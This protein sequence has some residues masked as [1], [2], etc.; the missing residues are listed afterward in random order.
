MPAKFEISRSGKNNEFYFHLKATNGEIILRSQG[1]KDLSSAKKGIASVQTNA[2]V[3][4]RY[5]VKKAKNGETYFDLHSR[6]AK[7]IGTSQ[8]YKEESGLK[9]GLTSV[10]KNAPGAKVV[11]Y[12]PAV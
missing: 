5:Q 12:K 11:D 2:V 9:K 4:A 6:N 7:V 8:M 1:Y 3:D 10:K